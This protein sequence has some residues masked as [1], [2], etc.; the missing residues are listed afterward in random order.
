[1]NSRH[2]YVSTLQ[3]TAATARCSSTLQSIR[4]RSRCARGLA[5]SISLWLMP[6]LAGDEDHA[7]R[8]QLGHVDG[9]VA[10]AR[11]GGHVAE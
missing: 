6:V 10:G 2:G 4:R 1:M 9:V 7:G 5:S 8:R 11:H 3:H